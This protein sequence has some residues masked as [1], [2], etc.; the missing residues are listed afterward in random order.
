MSKES[1]IPFSSG[2][3]ASNWYENNCMTCVKAYIPENGKYP[4]DKTMKSYCSIGKECRMKYYLDWGFV[5]GEI[6]L[7]Q[8]ETIGIENNLLVKRCREWSDRG[9]GG[10]PKGPKR[11]KPIPNN[12]MILPFALLEIGEKLDKNEIVN[13]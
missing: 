4:K 1:F 5:I 6:P 12:Q 8:A 10:N 3:D 13:Q 9:N 7:K 11:P 2:T